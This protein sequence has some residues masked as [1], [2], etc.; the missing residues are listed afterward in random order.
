MKARTRIWGIEV[1]YVKEILRLHFDLG[2]NAFNIA[3]SLSISPGTYRQDYQNSQ[4]VIAN[5]F[6]TKCDERR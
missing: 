3:K 2:V 5:A 6:R 1:F 4:G